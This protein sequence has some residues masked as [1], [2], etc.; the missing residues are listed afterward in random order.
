MDYYGV[1]WINV[2]FNVPLKEFVVIFGDFW[3]FQD[4][5]HGFVIIC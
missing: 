2:D 3:H 5:Y 4:V 1:I